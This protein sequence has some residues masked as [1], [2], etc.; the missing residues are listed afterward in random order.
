M[1]SVWTLDAVLSLTNAVFNLLSCRLGP[2]T[3]IFSH[4]SLYTLFITSIF[5][6]MVVQQT[7]LSQTFPNNR[8]RSIATGFPTT[9]TANNPLMVSGSNSGG[10]FFLTNTQP[11]QRL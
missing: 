7:F 1:K 11:H 8:M 2:K 10:N 9:G 6:N 3:H 4:I 5:K